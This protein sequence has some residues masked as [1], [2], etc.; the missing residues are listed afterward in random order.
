MLTLLKNCHLVSPELELRQ[1]SLLLQ[2]A[3]IK[4]ILPAG[5]PLPEADRTYDLAGEITVPGF[6]DIHC[7]GR[8]G[9]DFC[10]GTPAAFNTIGRGK[11]AEG[12]T[13]FLA[14]T[15]TVDIERLEATF[16]A[17]ADYR[18]H[19]AGAK[20]LGIHL[21]GPFINPD[22]VG[23]QNP[24]FLRQPDIALI[25][26]LNRVCPIRKVSFSPELPGGIDFCRA[27]SE[28]GI[29]PS[30]AHSAADYSL[31]KT[32]AATGM[33]HLTHFCNVMTPVHHLR[34]GMVGGGLLANDVYVEIIADGIHLCPEMIELIFN[35][36]TADRV[37][38]I[39][40]A[41]RGSAMPDGNYDL[42]GLPVSVV[43]GKAQ[44][45]NGA[46]AGS[47]LQLHQALRR[48]AEITGLP[49]TELIKTTAWNQAASL[50]FAKAG[51]LAKGYRADIVILNEQFEPQAVWLDGQLQ[52]E[53]AV[54][55]I[56]PQI[57]Q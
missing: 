47:T 32:A 30:G 18:R 4:D 37:M 24:D 2:D 11:L 21:E 43:N 55:D 28:R 12:V 53:N 8:G 10:D 19:P 49:L 17:A 27:L 34:F 45:A 36:K 40:D 14:T 48:T 35:L 46:V 16:A 29:M 38:L 56:L 31:F 26:R 41:M 23:A 42:G 54:K 51:K 25:D 20:L 39:T 6:I 7:H 13:G 5:T 9:A 1:A 57:N 33:K 22:C 50:H 3:W 52:N 15:M 44:L